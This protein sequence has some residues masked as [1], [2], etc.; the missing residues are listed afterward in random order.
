MHDYHFAIRRAESVLGFEPTVN[1]K[2]ALRR[3]VEDYQ[4]LC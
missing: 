3:T 1:W 2:E 4:R